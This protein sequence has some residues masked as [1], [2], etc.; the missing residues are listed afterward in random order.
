MPHVG[1]WLKDSRSAESQEKV[2]VIESYFFPPENSRD[3]IC[4]HP[5]YHR[6][7]F[8]LFPEE[9]IFCCSSRQQPWKS[10]WENI[11]TL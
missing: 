6:T 9:N 2:K 11:S 10:F 5:Q 7:C 3:K 1:D 8:I 4:V